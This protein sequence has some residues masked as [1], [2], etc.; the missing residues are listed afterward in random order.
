MGT[1]SFKYETVLCSFK[2]LQSTVIGTRIK[3]N[4][5]H[6]FTFQQSQPIT[7]RYGDQRLYFKTLKNFL[8]K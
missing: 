4:L 6:E 3:G 8:I 2:Y 1:K 7:E 5:N